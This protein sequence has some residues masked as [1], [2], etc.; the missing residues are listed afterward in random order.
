MRTAEASDGVDKA[1]ARAARRAATMAR[2]GGA[3][4]SLASA[5]V[6]QLQRADEATAA[7][8]SS[9]GALGTLGALVAPLHRFLACESPSLPFANRAA[10]K[11]T[12]FQLAMH[13]MQ[14]QHDE[15]LNSIETGNV[16]ELIIFIF[17]F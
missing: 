5:L 9:A 3:A 7:T 1:A 6:S 4:A 14:S 10:A 15:Q 16:N 12:L 2:H 11:A 8:P 17:F 13:T